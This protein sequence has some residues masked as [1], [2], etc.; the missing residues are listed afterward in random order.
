MNR[1]NPITY[2]FNVFRKLFLEDNNLFANLDKKYTKAGTLLKG[3]RYRE[4]LT[5]VEFA[6]KNRCNSS[7]SFQNGKRYS[8]YWKNNS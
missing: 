6:Q 1:F 7:R 8:S 4:G 3:L 5:Q 2:D